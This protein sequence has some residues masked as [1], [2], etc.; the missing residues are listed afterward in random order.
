MNSAKR[1][2]CGSRYPNREH[3]EASIHAT[4]GCRPTSIQRIGSDWADH[5]R[6]C[7]RKSLATHPDHR[8]AIGVLDRSSAETLEESLK[9]FPSDAD[10]SITVDAIDVL[11]FEAITESESVI[12]LTDS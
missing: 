4:R 1:R 5:D 8:D 11:A 3:L 9:V 12:V 6:G 10:D 2:S 7:R